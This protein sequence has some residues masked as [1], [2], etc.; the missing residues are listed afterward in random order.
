MRFAEA[1][2]SVGL[3]A[4]LAAVA[5]VAVAP[6][7]GVIA[8]LEYDR[9][10]A[11]KHDHVAEAGRVAE[12]AAGQATGL[13]GAVGDT[14]RAVAA[15]A[16][17]QDTDV[18]HC[19]RTLQGI[20]SR[21]DRY[22][23][24]A[25]TDS[26]ANVLCS[27]PV[28]PRPGSFDR[29]Q[30]FK[31]GVSTDGLLIGDVTV[32]PVSGVPTLVVSYG[33]NVPGRSERLAA[34]AGVDLQWMT[35]YLAAIPVRH[36]ARLLAF[37]QHGVPVMAESARHTYDQA[38]LAWMR[39]IAQAQPAQ[40]RAMNG[41]YGRQLGVATARIGNRER[42]GMTL[43]V[44]IDLAEATMFNMPHLWSLIVA[45]A[46]VLAVTATAV[47]L[48]A[49]RLV[50]RPLR[51]VTDA[52]EAVAKGN[53][54][55]RV[56]EPYP[57]GELGGF[58][59]AFDGMADNLSLHVRRITEHQREKAELYRRINDT[60]YRMEPGDGLRVAFISDRARDLFDMDPGVLLGPRDDWK[61]VEFIAPGLEQVN[62]M[63]RHAIER[64]R[65]ID[66]TYR[67]R[68]GLGNARWIWERAEP[69]LDQDGA[70][71]GYEGV[72][73]DITDSKRIEQDMIA[74]HRDLTL[75]YG[76]LLD[77]IAALAE[78]RDP[79]T[80]GHQR[81]VA[82]LAIAIARALNLPPH[83]ID[84]L[85]LAARIHD[86]G[87][88]GIPADILTKSGRLTDTEYAMVR[89]H[90][91]IGY[92]VL[93]GIE[94]PWPIAQIVLQHHE[95]LDGS[96]YPNGIKGDQMLAEARILAVADVVESM[97]SHRPYRPAR[98]KDEVKAELERGRGTIYDAEAVAVALR[99]LEH[100]ELHFDDDA[101]TLM[102]T[103]PP[104]DFS[105]ARSLGNHSRATL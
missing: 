102:A 53:L 105:E 46:G 65:P 54:G 71:Q 56:G 3:T 26:R 87:K 82:S 12:Y 75:H 50:L 79:Y 67:I 18:E 2:A 24:L 10:E 72:L 33:F 15:L 40:P 1:F 89:E 45:L 9:R 103:T 35:D 96:G 88:M 49:R 19:R 63:L 59:Q 47:T 23:G 68:T 104:M 94:F 30:W 44:A 13:A 17:A 86:V 97:A 38:Y 37:D 21:S 61:G 83:R 52:A 93:K 32:G 100:D 48:A 73:T 43:V 57:G 95:R 39:T 78:A 90:A 66:V 62:A 77:A 98:S 60:V 69:L 7:V 28:N 14:L 74:R 85:A 81:R 99:F 76:Q 4:R 22:T 101:E 92:D 55:A 31:D 6:F 42:G 80:A 51:R 27:A 25:L 91:K 36:G 34:F 20:L 64:R 84:G 8:G 29:T 5:L 11:D 41:P 70:F 16:S 58:M